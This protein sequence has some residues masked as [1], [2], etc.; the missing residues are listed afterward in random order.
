[1]ILSH[2]LII[3]LDCVST[4][5][6][7]YFEVTHDITNFCKAKIF[8]QIGKKTPLAVRFSTVGK[9]LLVLV[10]CTCQHHMLLFLKTVF[11]LLLL[12]IFYFSTLKIVV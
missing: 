8:E 9:Y 11:T 7:G 4:G 12:S 5:A 2:N 6:K 3:T 10:L 1:M